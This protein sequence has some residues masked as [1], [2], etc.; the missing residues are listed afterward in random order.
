MYAMN[1]I[2]PFRIFLAEANTKAADFEL[3]IVTA[4]NNEP[5][6]PQ[7]INKKVTRESCEQIVKELKKQGVTGNKAVQLGSGTMEVSKQWASFWAPDSVPASTK[8]PKTD[9]IIGDKYKISLKAGIGSRLMSGGRNESRATFF[10]AVE[11]TPDLEKSIKEKL[12]VLLPQ[13]SWPQTT[14]STTTVGL[15]QG[16]DEVLIKANKVNKELMSVLANAFNTNKNFMTAF[17]S[18]AMTGAVKFG[19]SDATAN[20]IL[21]VGWDGEIYSFSPINDSYI[22]SSVLKY[23]SPSVNFKSSSVKVKREGKTVKTGEY[24]YWSVVSLIYERGK[25]IIREELDASGS[26]ILSENILKNAWDK[27]KNFCKKIINKVI[28]WLKKQNIK[29]IIEDFFE[30]EVIVNF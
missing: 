15:K 17:V 1:S 28:S 5:K 20:Y 27:F 19:G 22:K 4:W 25:E 3:G 23:T 2:K 18:E 11:Q 14:P 21:N 9:I 30:F 6:W 16:A 10:A 7:K 13:L 24:R 12:L 8:T 29:T 26:N